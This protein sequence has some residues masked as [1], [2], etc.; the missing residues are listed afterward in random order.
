MRRG[1]F[2]LNIAAVVSGLLSVAMAAL[3]CHS[4]GEVDDLSRASGTKWVLVS[5]R[6]RIALNVAHLEGWHKHPPHHGLTVVKRNFKLASAPRL[7]PDPL[8]P[9]I[10]GET[11]YVDRFGFAWC[12][13]KPRQSAEFLREIT[14]Y[15]RIEGPGY[16]VFREGDPSHITV[17]PPELLATDPRGSLSTLAAAAGAA[18]AAAK[19]RTR[20][21]PRGA[22]ASFLIV[23][24]AT[25]SSPIDVA[26]APAYTIS[27]PHAFMVALLAVLPTAKVISAARR[28]RRVRAWRARGLCMTCGYDLRETPERCPECG[29]ATPL[30]REAN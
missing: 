6:G 10:L 13:F 19:Q 24:G 25:G 30:S 7:L 5:W 11:R 18:A 28:Y 26:A 15:D 14:S 21:D 1:R 22:S 9:V 3:W 8:P 23:S 29:T 17:I 12:V 2:V 16:T 20:S 4:F 27:V